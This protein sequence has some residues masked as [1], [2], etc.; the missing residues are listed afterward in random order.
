LKHM[1]YEGGYRHD[2][3]EVWVST[4]WPPCRVAGQWTSLQTA[5]KPLQLSNGKRVIIDKPRYYVV[6]ITE[7]CRRLRRLVADWKLFVN[8]VWSK[9]LT[10]AAWSLKL[11]LENRDFVSS[12]NSVLAIR[13]IILVPSSDMRVGVYRSRSVSG[14]SGFTG[15][16]WLLMRNHVNCWNKTLRL[17]RS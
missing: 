5:G 16:E 17:I 14:G 6:L 8:A 15:T 2:V 1:E 7:E 13:L 10:H 3:A 12:R 11:R 4:V 9:Q